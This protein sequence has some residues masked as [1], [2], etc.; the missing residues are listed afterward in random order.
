VENAP[1]NDRLVLACFYV[2]ED[3]AE[4]LIAEIRIPVVL[5]RGVRRLEVMNRERG[6]GYG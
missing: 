6:E 2:L 1:L 3:V 5:A 4:N